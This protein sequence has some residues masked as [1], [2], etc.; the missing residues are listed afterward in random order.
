M[1]DAN[2]RT[3]ANLRRSSNKATLQLTI[4]RSLFKSSAKDFSPETLEFAI[5]SALEAFVPLGTLGRIYVSVAN[6][7]SD[8]TKFDIKETTAGL[9]ERRINYG[10]PFNGTS[11]RPLK[12]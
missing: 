8:C 4:P 10:R 12:G 2:L 5:G 7:F 3:K 6:L 11:G 1:C 9:T